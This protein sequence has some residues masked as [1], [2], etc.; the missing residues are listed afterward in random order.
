[1]TYNRVVASIITLILVIIFPPAILIRN[2]IQ[3]RKLTDGYESFFSISWEEKVND[4][5][6]NL[7]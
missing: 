7:F 2:I 5:E 1:M 4:V 3:K 6:K